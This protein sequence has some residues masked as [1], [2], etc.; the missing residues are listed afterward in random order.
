V[1]KVLAA[2]A[3]VAATITRQVRKTLAAG[4]T[5]LATMVL[6]PT[7]QF[8]GQVTKRTVAVG[9]A[10]V[11]A[12]MGALGR[13]RSSRVGPTDA[14]GGGGPTGASGGPGDTGVI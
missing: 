6:V 3:T 12:A 2:P 7:T 14:E 13:T 4:A 5:A 1:G 11:T 9:S 10:M 8:A